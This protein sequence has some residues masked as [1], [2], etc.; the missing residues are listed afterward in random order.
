MPRFDHRRTV[1]VVDAPATR[2][3][4]NAISR[5]IGARQNGN[6]A[7]DRFGGVNVYLVDFPVCY[8]GSDNMCVKLMWTV[9][10]IDILAASG[11]ETMV[12][13]ASNCGAKPILSH[14]SPRFR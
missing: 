8:R 3:A 4:S 9:D 13:F 11:Y 10:V 2:Q 7:G 12:F 14:A 6:N 1:F 5:H